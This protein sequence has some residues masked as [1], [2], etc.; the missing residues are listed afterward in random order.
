VGA[1]LGRLAVGAA[2]GSV[3][4]V[5]DG[6]ELWGAPVGLELGSAVG[7]TL[8]SVEGVLNGCELWGAPVGLELGSAVGL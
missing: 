2:L 4:G 5:L 3:D 1:A 8:G 6:C 7:V